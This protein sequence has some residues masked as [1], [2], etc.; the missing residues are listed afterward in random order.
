VD[1][2]RRALRSVRAELAD[3]RAEV[4]ALT[5]DRDQAV[6][7]ACAAQ[8][9]RDQAR[10]DAEERV[11]AAQ[12]M[13]AAQ[14]LDT[15]RARELE[16]SRTQLLVDTIVAAASGLRR[17]LA[18][19]PAQLRPADAVAS[20]AADTPAAPTIDRRG[21]DLADP[22]LLD[23]LLGLPQVHLIVDGYNV[24]KNG[25]GDLPLAAQRQRLLAGLA[26]LAAQTH[27]EITCCF[28]GAALD[29]HVSVSA[30]RGVR[31]LFSRP[32]QTADELIRQLV[33]AEPQGRPLVVI[34]TDREVA[35]SARRAGAY[36]LPSDS[37]LRRLART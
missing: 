9:E 18:L 5:H 24:T 17:E 33:H 6:A 2:L 22:R 10:R 4:S 8:A 36:A 19:P 13:V 15:R 1:Q 31:V 14:R 7:N 23:D 26:G 27:A 3:A 29:G 32:G 11:K 20:A 28:D 34:S 35:T 12:A 21:R 16:D 25:F 37:L 30:P